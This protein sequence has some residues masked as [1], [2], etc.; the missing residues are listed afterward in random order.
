MF[1]E[2][3]SKMPDI[4]IPSKGIEISGIIRFLKLMALSILRLFRL[5]NA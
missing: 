1:R 5:G 4:F 2:K 3:V